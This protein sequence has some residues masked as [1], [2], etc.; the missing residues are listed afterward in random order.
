MQPFWYVQCHL[1]AYDLRADHLVLDYPLGGSPLRKTIFSTL[2]TPSCPWLSRVE[3]SRTLPFPCC[4]STVS[5]SLFRS[6]LAA[7]SMRPHGC[8]LFGIS[9]RH[10]L[11]AH[12]LFLGLQHLS[13]FSSTMISEPWGKELCVHVSSGTGF[14]YIVV[15][16]WSLLGREVSLR[17]MR[18]AL[19]CGHRI[20][21]EMALRIIL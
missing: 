4:M 13:M 8:G 10:G 7:T 5:S 16:L 11:P 15:L 2:S 18:T 20:N 3:A 14:W 19:I 6:C 9:R 12:F 17:G 21:I 1:W